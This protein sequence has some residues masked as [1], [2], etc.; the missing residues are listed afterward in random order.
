[1]KNNRNI[2][3]KAIILIFFLLIFFVPINKTLASGIEFVPQVT[4]PGSNFI[5]GQNTTIE[6]GT[7]ALA[8]YVKSIYNYLLAIVGLL[9]A[10]VLMVS[11][12]IWLT[13]GGNTEKIGQAKGW[14]TGSLTG[15]ILMLTSY[16]ILR[17]INPYLVDFRTND[18][19]N[20]DRR[21]KNTVCVKYNEGERQGETKDGKLFITRTAAEIAENEKLKEEGKTIQNVAKECLEDEVCAKIKYENPND[22][23]ECTK[24]NKIRCCQYEKMDSLGITCKTITNGESCPDPKESY[25][26]IKL[27]YIYEEEICDLQFNNSGRN[28]CVPDGKM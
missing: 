21:E 14:M 9:A 12:V 6:G 1:M 26:D 7:K 28:A 25:P 27:K 4:I 2:T 11:G 18:V 8:I 24:K 19:D 20:I 16:V 13:A 17:T 23:F 3:L 22:I 15:L 10:I 5:K